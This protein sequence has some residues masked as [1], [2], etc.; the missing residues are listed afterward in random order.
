MTSGSQKIATFFS[1]LGEFWGSFPKSTASKFLALS[2]ISWWQ[3]L[4]SWCLFS[5]CLLKNFFFFC[6]SHEEYVAQITFNWFWLYVC[7]PEQMVDTMAL[8]LRGFSS[9]LYDLTI[10]RLV[11]MLFLYLLIHLWIFFFKS[12]DQ[13]ESKN[14]H[15]GISWVRIWAPRVFKTPQVIPLCS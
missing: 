9:V 11:E 5:V 12:W 15:I 10:E 4:Q 3:P 6:C 13:V 14:N 2:A 1:V 8:S 7:T